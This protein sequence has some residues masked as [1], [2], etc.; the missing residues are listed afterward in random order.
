MDDQKI[1]FLR[2]Q[3]IGGLV[4]ALLT[5]AQRLGFTEEETKASLGY[6]QARPDVLLRWKELGKAFASHFMN[7][8]DDRAL[9][10]VR[11]LIQEFSKI[12]S[13]EKAVFPDSFAS[14]ASSCQKKLQLL[15]SRSVDVVA[16]EKKLAEL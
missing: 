3:H 16:L 5:S 4:D 10:D 11:M 14:L 12:A 2:Q 15:K 7:G 6:A 1:G 9:E 13:F 8:A